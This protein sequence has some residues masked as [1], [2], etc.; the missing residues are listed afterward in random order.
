MGTRAKT[1]RR[2]VRLETGASI[3]RIFDTLKSRHND[4][5]LVVQRCVEAHERRSVATQT[6]THE[7]ETSERVEGYERIGL[8]SSGNTDPLGT[9][10]LDAQILEVAGR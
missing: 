7:R 2:L 4:G 9:D 3:S 1:S 6:K 5:R 10:S 8:R